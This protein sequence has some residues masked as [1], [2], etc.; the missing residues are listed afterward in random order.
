[1]TIKWAA[2]E[3]LA[4]DEGII[5]ALAI[6]Q[7]G[8]LKKMLA[9]AA[10]KKANEEDIVEFKKLISSELTPY[11]SAILLDP[12]YGLPAAKKRAQNTGLLV[13]YEKTGYDTTEPGRMPD[14]LPDWSATR[15]KEAGADAVKFMLYYDVDENNEINKK[16]QV[17]VE[18]IGEECET[19]GLPFFLEL[20]SYDAQIVDTNSR[21][22]AKVKPHKV[23]KM[24]AEFAKPRYRVD[25]LKVEVPVNMAYVE[26]FSTE[27]EPV[28]SQQEAA[29]FYKEQNALTNGVPFIFLSAGVSA[30]LFQKTLLFAAKSGS[31]FN[32]VLC[33]R[34]T[35]RGG[36]T[37]F[38]KDGEE[39]GR[40]WLNTVGKNNIEAL[41]KAL[42]ES[43]TSLFTKA[44]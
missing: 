9:K 34:A 21:E 38:A 41:N 27:H 12:E 29:D 30:E 26:G 22:Y 4:N 35:W 18:R 20:M 7:R 25:V 43:A 31:S 11:A 5:A 10:N 16:K 36:I 6:D 8:S 15:L 1:M 23:N 42:K 14:L 44:K 17:F 19:I 40:E 3:K 39:A 13:A 28:Y 2:L 24:V 33:G 32:G 37:P